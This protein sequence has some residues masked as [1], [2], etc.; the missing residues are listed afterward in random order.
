MS[1]FKNHN[2]GESTVIAVKWYQ[3]KNIYS[4]LSTTDVLKSYQVLKHQVDKV[5]C[6][7]FISGGACLCLNHGSGCQLEHSKKYTLCFL[8]FYFWNNSTCMNSGH[9]CSGRG[10]QIQN[11]DYSSQRKA[12]SRETDLLVTLCN[13]RYKNAN[14]GRKF[15]FNWKLIKLKRNVLCC[16]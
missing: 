7:R 4:Q 5:Y 2:V 10:T 13:L 12:F 16:R 6:L 3:S 15:V 8:S 9:V 1:F 14:L 11:D